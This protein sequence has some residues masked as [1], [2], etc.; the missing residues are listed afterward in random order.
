MKHIII[1]LAALAFSVGA[2]AQEALWSGSQIQSP[3]VNADGTVTFSIFAP[4]AKKIF[5][6]GDMFPARET[7]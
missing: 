1:P 4:T 7:L 5:V 2:S 3:K 6:T